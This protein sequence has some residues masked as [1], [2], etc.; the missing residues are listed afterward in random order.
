VTV[1]LDL[2]QCA[3]LASRVSRAATRLGIDDYVVDE[4][5]HDVG[6]DDEQ[7]VSHGELL[8]DDSQFALLGVVPG[9]VEGT[10]KEVTLRMTRAADADPGFRHVLADLAVIEGRDLCKSDGEPQ[11]G[12]A[13]EIPRARQRCD[14]RPLRKT[15]RTRGT[16]TIQAN[17]PA[18]SRA[19]GS[20]PM[21]GNAAS[22]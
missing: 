19:W 21:P 16:A 22:M 8:V 4:V 5:E 12:L 18:V 15:P 6:D 13:V 1:L 20:A 10:V 7:D 3:A 2:A 11:R 17:G 9:D 14:R